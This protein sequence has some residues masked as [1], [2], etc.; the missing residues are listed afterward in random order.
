MDP[1]RVLPGRGYCIHTA[2]FQMGLPRAQGGVCVL[3][4]LSDGNVEVKPRDGEG[5][6]QTN[7]ILGTRSAFQCLLYVYIQ[8]RCGF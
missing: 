8:L 4:Y 3:C 5:F 7:G 2:Y 1:G 6:S